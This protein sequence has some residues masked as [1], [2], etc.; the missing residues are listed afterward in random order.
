MIYPRD[1]TEAAAGQKIL[2]AYNLLVQ[3]VRGWRWFKGDGMRVLESPQGT[4]VMRMPELPVWHHPWRV[5]L[6]TDGARAQVAPG[7]CNGEIPEMDGR[8]MDGLMADGTLDPKGAPELEIKKAFFK[9]GLSWVV[10]RAEADKDLKPAKYTVVQTKEA[11]WGA[12]YSLAKPAEKGGGAR[13]DFPLA[14]LRK[15][16]DAT[17]VMQAAHFN[18]RCRVRPGKFWFFV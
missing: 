7:L 5:V 16:G 4:V 10:L 17:V 12:G 11:T 3:A 1:I 18:I 15:R 9:D 8:P 13:G 14:M 2:P 6:G